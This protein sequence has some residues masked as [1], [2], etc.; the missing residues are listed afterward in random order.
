M[1]RTELDRLLW[2]RQATIFSGI[3]MLLYAYAGWGRGGVQ[4]VIL[5]ILTL[6]LESFQLVHFHVVF[7]RVIVDI[8]GCGI[9]LTML[10]F[11]SS[12]W[13]STL[14]C[15]HHHDHS[16]YCCPGDMSGH[17]QDEFSLLFY[18]ILGSMNSSIFLIKGGF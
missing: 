9:V 6:M 2:E 5:E 4:E 1:R 3:N 8:S 18:K 17:L 7:P 14:R 15:H 12:A 10:D 16:L 13:P 11:H